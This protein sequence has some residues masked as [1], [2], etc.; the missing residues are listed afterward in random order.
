M[1]TYLDE[2]NEVFNTILEQEYFSEFKLG[3]KSIE[4]ELSGLCSANCQYC[5]LKKH[6]KDLFPK[7]LYNEQNIINNIN[8]LLQWYV[9][10]LSYGTSI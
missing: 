4:L 1:K 7:E 8:L 6:Q 10:H 3:N 5:Y 9:N 2:D